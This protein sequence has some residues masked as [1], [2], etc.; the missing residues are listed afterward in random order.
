[1]PAAETTATL[2]AGTSKR[3][4]TNTVFGAEVVETISVFRKIPPSR[5]TEVW[6]ASRTGMQNRVSRGATL[7]RKAIGTTSIGEIKGIGQLCA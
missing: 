3:S 1:M 6:I 2:A 4:E 7:L 5:S